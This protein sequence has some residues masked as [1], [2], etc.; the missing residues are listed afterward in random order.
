MRRV[1][2]SCSLLE[3]DWWFSQHPAMPSGLAPARWPWRLALGFALGASALGL[4]QAVR[5]SGDRSGELP[6]VVPNEPIAVLDA[7]FLAEGWA[8]HPERDPLPLER[9]RAGNA[10]S[11]L[12]ACSGT[13][14]GLCRYDYQRGQQAIA[15]VTV[16]GVDGDGVVHSWFVPD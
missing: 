11:S 7:R 2:C 16:P 8:P 4:A 9:T 1:A 3:L 6:L 10:L 13:G 14:L 12:S 5:S 15:V